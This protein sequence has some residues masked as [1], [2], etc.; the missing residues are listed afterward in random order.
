M[1]PA[2]AS[3]RVLELLA[4]YRCLTAQVFE[5]G[6]IFA[7]HGVSGSPNASERSDS[8]ML[9]SS[10]APKWRGDTF[11]AT[12]DRRFMC[13]VKYL[14]KVN[15]FSHAGNLGHESGR[16]KGR[17]D[18]EIPRH[19]PYRR[20]RRRGGAAAVTSVAP[21]GPT[22]RHGRLTAARRGCPET[23]RN[24]ERRRGLWRRW[25][26]G[27]CSHERTAGWWARLPTRRR[28]HATVESIHLRGPPDRAP[29]GTRTR[30]SMC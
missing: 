11:K 7:G 21:V 24:A 26:L 1:R 15:I 23:C 6:S 28:P 18:R 12:G 29:A 10:P 8:P 16:S 14:R 27:A 9:R 20:R 25:E 22:R 4:Q 13:A 3:N 5:F 17:R 30:S 19:R 2:P